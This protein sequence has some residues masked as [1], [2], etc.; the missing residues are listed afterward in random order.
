MTSATTAV[1]TRREPELLGQTVVVIGGSAGI[2]LETARRA[3]RRGR[4]PHPH[5]AQSRT[6][7]ASSARA[8][9]AA[10]RGL[11]RQRSGLPAVVLPGSPNP[12]RP[13]DGHRRRSPLR[14]SP[15]K[16][17]APLEQT[18]WETFCDLIGLEPELH[19]DEKSS[20]ATK[21]RVAAIIATEKFHDV[22]RWSPGIISCRCTYLESGTK[23]REGQDHVAVG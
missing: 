1:S 4:Q 11:R 19:D 2:G 14:A 20:T 23:P 18:F 13:R 15:R 5:W 17:A 7:Q 6:P 9:R 12:D 21:A 3:P 22:P 16:A 8:R 10:H